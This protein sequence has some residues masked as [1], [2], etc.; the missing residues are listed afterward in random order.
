MLPAPQSFIS[1]GHPLP[2]FSFS[3]P[4]QPFIPHTI[5][6]SLHQGHDPNSPELFKHNIRTVHEQ[7]IQLQSMARR[8]L[9]RIQNAYQ[10]GNNPLVTESEIE[11]LRQNL[12]LVIETMRHTG[13]GALP[14][15][16]QPNSEATPVPTEQQLLTNTT[17][18]LQALYD[19]VQRS[20]DS[21][22]AV[23]N[24]LSTDHISRSGK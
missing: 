11:S 8:V 9:S 15:L 5:Q 16:P 12:Y 4:P 20:Y 21:A 19:K 7:V 6:D 17:Q 24:L 3:N 2:S 18:S 23:A 13:V 10:T 1:G 14:I 22:T